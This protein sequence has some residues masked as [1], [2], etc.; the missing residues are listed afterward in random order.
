MF[1]PLF[2]I[3]NLQLGLCRSYTPEFLFD[4]EQVCLDY[5]EEMRQQALSELPNTAIIMYQ[6]VGFPSPA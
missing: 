2:V 3:C 5:S 6:C 1:A 4:K